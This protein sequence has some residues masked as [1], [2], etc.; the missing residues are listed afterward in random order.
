MS[1]RRFTR[2]RGN[3]LRRNVIHMVM[4][5]RFVIKAALLCSFSSSSSSFRVPLGPLQYR[6]SNTHYTLLMSDD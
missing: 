3:S 1:L 2:F 5:E 6:I 4:T